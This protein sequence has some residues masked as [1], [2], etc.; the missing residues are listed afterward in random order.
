MPPKVSILMAAFNHEK[1]ISE[2]INSVLSQTFQEWELIIVDDCST[3]NTVSKIKSYSDPRIRVFI[4]QH[5]EGQ[6][7]TVRKCL[8]EATGEY[9]AILNS[10]DSFHSAK[11][12]KQVRYLENNPAVGAVFSYATLIDDGGKVFYNKS[13]FYCELFEK[14]N[15]DR[16]Q[17]LNYFFY[18][19]NCLCHP[20]V[21]VRR[22]CHEE[23]GPY[24]QFLTQLSDFD[25]WIRLLFRWE[26][27]IIPEYLTNFRIREGEANLSGQNPQA[28]VRSVWEYGHILKGYLKI[29]NI[30]DFNKIFPGFI[31]NNKFAADRELIPFY[32]CMAAL[33]IDSPPLHLFAVENLFVLIADYRMA[34]KMAEQCGFYYQDFIKITGTYDVFN[35]LPKRRVLF[36]SVRRVANFLFPKETTAR[37]FL[38]KVKNSLWGGNKCLK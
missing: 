31:E 25:F 26:I 14:D 2:A 21:L 34:N 23:L 13:N 30:E 7:A 17:W 27:Y 19:G 35:I 20:S 12:E 9:I 32:I 16:Y 4:S 28:I 8:E 5:N 15:R 11:L 29:P 33:K 1:Y 38:I 37:K 22:E 18:Q 24:K 36:R 3:D 10:D 6:F